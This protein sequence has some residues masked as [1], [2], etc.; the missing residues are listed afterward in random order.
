MSTRIVEPDEEVSAQPS[1][2]AAPPGAASGPE[3]MGFFNKLGHY[4]G[5]GAS[6]IAVVVM[7]MGNS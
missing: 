7:S 1:F 4:L 5:Q 6:A 3:D 2:T